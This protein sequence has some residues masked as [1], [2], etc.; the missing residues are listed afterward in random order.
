MKQ[1]YYYVIVNK[2]GKMLLNDSKLPIYWLK[3]VAVKKAKNYPGYH[4]EK[5]AA[6]GMYL[7]AK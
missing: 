5:I 3:K 2:K 1:K 4:V 7:L 6:A